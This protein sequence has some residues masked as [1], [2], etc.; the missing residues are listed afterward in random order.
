MN[1]HYQQKREEVLNYSENELYKV[2]KRAFDIIFSVFIIIAISPILLLISLLVK[3]EDGGPIIFKQKRAGLNGETF[4]IFKFRTMKVQR[5]QKKNTES[6]YNWPTRVPDDFVF[7]M[8]DDFNPNVTKIGRF[9]RKSSLDELP[10][11]FNVVKGEM[12]IVGPR[13][14]IIEITNCYDAEQFQRLLVKPG[15][16]GWAQVNGRSEMNHGRKVELDLD[17]IA[18][19][20]FLQDIKIILMTIKQ[21]FFGKGAI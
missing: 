9:L 10:Q 20:S 11:F 1:P 17:Y 19:Q 13:P 7:K 3:L 5:G 16:T 15:I 14:E 21:T 18:N 12:S 8:T 6:L 4:N 2:A